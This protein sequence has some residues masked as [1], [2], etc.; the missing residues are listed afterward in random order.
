MASKYRASQNRT[1]AANNLFPLLQFS[2]DTR[3]VERAV[4]QRFILYPLSPMQF[5][6]A[7][8]V[9][10]HSTSAK[11]SSHIVLKHSTRSEFF[12]RHCTASRL[13]NGRSHQ[14]DTYIAIH[15]HKPTRQEL[16]HLIIQCTSWHADAIKT[17]NTLATS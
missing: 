9:R 8:S 1:L 4:V 15:A 11:L 13:P 7:Q 12:V 5:V 16:Q 6:I 10:R 2:P 3:I 17:A 14:A